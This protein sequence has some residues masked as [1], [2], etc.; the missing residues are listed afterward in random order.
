MN[1]RG[2]R[3]SETSTATDRTLVVGRDRPIRVSGGHRLQHH[4]GKC[5]CPQ[6]HNYEIRVEVTVRVR[7]EEGWIVD[8]G[9][10]TAV[11]S[12]WDHIW[13]DAPGT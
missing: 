3:T 8:K 13:D 7:A 10:I 9:D 12:E 5:S 1:A 4:E 6:G 2:S 11:L